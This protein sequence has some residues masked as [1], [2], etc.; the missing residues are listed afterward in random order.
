MVD[1]ND[2]RE[3]K[4][5][6][7]RDR[8]YLAR[9]NGAILR[10]SQEGKRKTKLDDVWTFGTSEN[11]QKGYFEIA[12]VP[13]HRIVATAFLGEQPTKE[14]VVD[15]IDTNRKNNRPSNLRWLTRFENV[16]Y[17]EITR[18]KIE[19]IV[20][21]NIYEYLENPAKYSHMFS[22][23]DFSW[24]RTVTEEEAKACLEKFKRQSEADKS[25]TKLAKQKNWRT[26]TKFLCCPIEIVGDPI[27][28]YL[29][30]LKI[31]ENF[32]TNSHG[33]SIILDFA[34]VNDSII[35]MTTNPSG[36]K[37]YALTKITYENGYFMHTNLHSF[38]SL[39]G[40]TKYFVIAQGLEWAGGDTFDDYC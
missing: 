4:S 33:D 29:K 38:F 2:Y 23:T 17:N 12:G 27:D 15:H 8:E 1:V 6:V 24:M 9:D 26:L 16:V 34:K 40:A 36:V 14:H 18:R 20:C 39:D 19:S 11:K 22:N 5:C 10:K 35:V 25:L 30:N 7:Y 21:T 32:G 31:G 37:P 28:C 13:I 3:E